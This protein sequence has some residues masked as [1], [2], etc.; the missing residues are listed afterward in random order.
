MIGNVGSVSDIFGFEHKN[1][2]D[3]SELESITKSACEF[4]SN[5][6]SF[7]M[8]GMTIRNQI[9]ATHNQLGGI[10]KVSDKYY[11][12]RS[13][14]LEIIDRLGG[15]DAF[16]SGLLHGLIKNYRPDQMINFANACFALTQ[17]IK[18]DVNYFE[19]EEI[20]G[21]SSI[22]YRGHIKR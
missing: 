8:I 13:Y 11:F 22:N 16:V 2:N 10:I 7:D 1:S 3:F 12:G 15:G 21:F 6:Y 14:N 19:E 5:K 4:I 9:H 18:G 20:I 17:T